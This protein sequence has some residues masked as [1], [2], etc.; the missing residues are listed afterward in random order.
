MEQKKEADREEKLLELQDSLDRYAFGRETMDVEKIKQIVSRLDEA[1]GEEPQEFQKEE[2]W[3]RI[4]AAYPEKREEGAN[5]EDIRSGKKISRRNGGKRIFRLTGRKRRL[6]HVG[7]A[8]AVLMVVLF[9]GANIG[10]YATEKK[11]VFEIVD[12]ARNGTAFRVNGDVESL[13][14]ET[15]KCFFYSWNELPNEYKKFIL[16]PYGIPEELALYQIQVREIN[17]MNACQV[18]YISDDG[19]RNLDMEIVDYQS[20]EFAFQDFLFEEAEYTA[21]KEEMV[22]NIVVK[23]Y[24]DLNK[25]Y[26]A[27]FTDNVKWFTFYSDL[28][29]DI[30]E[31]II[32]KTI[33]NNF[34]RKF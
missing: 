25:G 12:E 1:L 2:V 23:Y 21:L 26:V 30:F 27:R 5:A 22:N 4:C 28:S 8:A 10:T 13:E 32:N 14:F 15:D 3:E 11:N 7:I 16:I 6:F 34:S 19:K 20:N 31:D 29:L 18:R 24:V 9:I 17:T 33:D